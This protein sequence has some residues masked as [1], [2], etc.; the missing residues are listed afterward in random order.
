MNTS[1]V[2]EPRL[3]RLG[4]ALAN[5][6]QRWFPDPAVVAFLGIVVV[7]LVGVLAGEE[8]VRL[9]SEGGKSFWALVPFTMQMVMVIVGGHVVGSTGA[10]RHAIRWLAG[11]PRSP[12]SAVALV[13]LFA[14]LTS[15]ISW[16]SA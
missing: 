12:R 13:A 2:S 9:A 6:S 5:W 8:P 11:L 3:A 4:V 16:A 10:A 14:M 7:F 15:L 1:G